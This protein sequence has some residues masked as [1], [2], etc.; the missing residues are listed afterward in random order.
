MISFFVPEIFKLSYYANLV[1]DYSM[2]VGL[3]YRKDQVFCLV[4]SQMVILNF[5]EAR[6]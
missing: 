5:E 1:T 2:K 6:D 3:A 4:E